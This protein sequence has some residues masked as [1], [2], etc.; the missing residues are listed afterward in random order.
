LLGMPAVILIPITAIMLNELLMNNIS[1][2]F[3]LFITFIMIWAMLKK[4]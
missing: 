1:H 4:P 2:K 3:Y